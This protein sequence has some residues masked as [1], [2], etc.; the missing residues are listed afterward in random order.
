MMTQW[1][2]V[3]ATN[4]DILFSVSWMQMLK[5]ECCLPYYCMAKL[6]FVCVHTQEY[7]DT[8][9]FLKETP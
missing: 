5:E 7:L 3:L 6:E 4:F 2:K 9:K 8:Q 1:V